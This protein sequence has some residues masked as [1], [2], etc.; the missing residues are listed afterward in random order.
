MSKYKLV[1]VMRGDDWI[2]RNAILFNDNGSVIAV[3]DTTSQLDDNYIATS[4]TYFTQWREIQQPV[5]KPF[6]NNESM[7]HLKDCWFRVNG[8]PR[9]FR[10]TSYNYDTYNVFYLGDIWVNRIDLF[11]EYEVK[12][13]GKWQPVGVL[14]AQEG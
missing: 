10:P 7:E 9:E 8:R 2:P 5:W 13:N 3:N 1:E 11:K 4:S 14:E 12:L 6:P